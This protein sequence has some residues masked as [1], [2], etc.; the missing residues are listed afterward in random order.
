M[1]TFF[2][3]LLTFI[4]T[5]GGCALFARSYFLR[6]KKVEDRAVHEM[7][8]HVARKQNES[9]TVLASLNL[10]VIAYSS[11]GILLLNNQASGKMIEEIPHN[12]VDFLDKYDVDQKIRSGFLLD[13]QQVEINYVYQDRSYRLSVQKRVLARDKNAGHILV[14]QDITQQIREEQQ[15]KEFVANVSH[16]LKTPLTTM[17]TYSESLLDWGIDEKSRESIKK[18]INKL[19]D[20]SLRMEKL[21]NDL[22]LLSRIDGNAIYTRIEK[23]ELLPIVRSCIERLYP[24]AEKKHIEFTSYTVSDKPVAYADR[25]ALERIILNLLNNSIKY[26][27]EYGEIKVYAG[28]LVD[29]IYFRVTDNGMGIPSEAQNNIFKRF[30]RVDSTGSR[31]HGGTGLGLAIVKELVDLHLGQIDLK[32]EIGKGSDFTVTLPGVKKTMRTALY[33]LT[34][35]GSCSHNITKAAQA[36]L[37]ILA[38]KLGIM[39]KWKSLQQREIDAIFKAIDVSEPIF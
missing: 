38:E 9:Q 22:L 34:E 36:D 5:S 12:F 31:A 35:N 18:D 32:S 10:G 21:I 24:E 13:K 33:E 16:E 23:I 39:A 26:T 37:D 30:Y 7:L 3:V 27:Q 19:Y 4:I 1:G 29:E 28:T 15:R 11:D 8:G 6:R 20:G 2:A 17:K 14:I 25:S